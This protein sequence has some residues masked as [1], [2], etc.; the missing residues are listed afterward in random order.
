MSL[1]YKCLIVLFKRANEISLYI[2]NF[3]IKGILFIFN[4]PDIFYYE[5]NTNLVFTHDTFPE[6]LSSGLQVKRLENQLKN[7]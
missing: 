1:C 2:A 5:I 7:V 4:C 6:Y 3:H